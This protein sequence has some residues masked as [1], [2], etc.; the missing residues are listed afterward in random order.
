V[1]GDITAASDLLT[2]SRRTGGVAARAMVWGGE[3]VIA[4]HVISTRADAGEDRRLA[5]E[6]TAGHWYGVYRR[7]AD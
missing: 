4:R 3:E 7:P 1:P 2:A 6:L 5:R